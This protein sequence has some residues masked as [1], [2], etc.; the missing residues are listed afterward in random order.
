MG[1]RACADPSPDLLLLLASRPRRDAAF[2]P[3]DQAC[4]SDPKSSD[5]DHRRE[6]LVDTEDVLV[7]DDQVAEPP[8]P[9]DSDEELRDD[10]P[11]QAP[12][13]REPDARED[14][15]KCGRDYDV[16]PQAPLARVERARHLEKI[17]VDVT[18]ALLRV[19]EDREDT[20]EGDGDDPRR[21][22]LELE[23]ESDERDER[24]RRDRIERAHDRIE[25][26]VGGAPPPGGHPDEQ[27]Q[28]DG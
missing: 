25:R 11:D 4:E 10:H 16:P 19:D 18:D 6:H 2:Q 23:D 14:E 5:D 26:V 20:E 13:D 27:A 15:R 12:A 9:D 28:G 7:R 1:T 8:G 24:D 21:V 22:T 3:L 17:A